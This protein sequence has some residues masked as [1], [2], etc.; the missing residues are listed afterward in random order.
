MLLDSP[1]TDE[2][3]AERH[4]RSMPVLRLYR[5]HAVEQDLPVPTR[6]VGFIEVVCNR[7][8]SMGHFKARCLVETNEGLG[9][10][11]Y[12]ETKDEHCVRQDITWEKQPEENKKVA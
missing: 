12:Y 8:P 5:E 6:V 4:L 11:E 10:M 3:L 9:F 2:E 7:T 1:L